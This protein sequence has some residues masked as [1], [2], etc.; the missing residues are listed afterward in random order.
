MERRKPRLEEYNGETTLF[1]LEKNKEKKNL[2]QI[3]C[4]ALAMFW[5]LSDGGSFEGGLAWSRWQQ[6]KQNSFLIAAS[7][8]AQSRFQH[9]SESAGIS[10]QSQR[11]DSGSRADPDPSVRGAGQSTWRDSTP[12]W[13]TVWQRE[14]NDATFSTVTQRQ[15]S[16]RAA[17]LLQGVQPSS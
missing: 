3:K 1:Q 7:F 11:R 9:L 5:I 2:Q 10:A 17:G 15:S 8:N 4:L 12:W 6:W 16:Q 13:T 14:R